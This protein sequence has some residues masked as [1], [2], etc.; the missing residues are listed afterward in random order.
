MRTGSAFFMAAIVSAL[1]LSLA[2]APGCER[3]ADDTA[4]S[5]NGAETQ[6]SQEVEGRSSVP[7]KAMDQAERMKSE[8]E[9]RQKEMSDMAESIGGNDQ[10]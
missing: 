6:Q 8:M 5:A 10:Q 9:Q 3:S 4:D 1:G 2:A 7:G